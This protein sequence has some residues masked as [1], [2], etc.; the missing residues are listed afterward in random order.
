MLFD[1]DLIDR[2]GLAVHVEI[3]SDHVGYLLGIPRT[4]RASGASGQS[5]DQ[6]CG[7]NDSPAFPTWKLSLMRII[8]MTMRIV[9]MSAGGFSK[10]RFGNEE[11]SR[12][13][14]VEI[15]RSIRVCSRDRGTSTQH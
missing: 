8:L 10:V 14:G 4:S 11:G 2:L 12:E 7:S 5:I 1:R 15:A 9:L 6:S 3:H 13:V